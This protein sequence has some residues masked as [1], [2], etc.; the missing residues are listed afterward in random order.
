MKLYLTRCVSSCATLFLV[1]DSSGIRC[2]SVRP[3]SGLFSDGFQITGVLNGQQTD[4]YV[5]Q[6]IFPNGRRFRIQEGGV[7]RA[8]VLLSLNGAAASIRLDRRPCGLLGS[9]LLGEYTLT[10]AAGEPIFSQTLHKRQGTA[11]SYLLNIPD[12]A[13]APVCLGIALCL[14][15]SLTV[16]RGIFIPVSTD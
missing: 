10:D 11:T 15:R 8:Q 7:R 14:S 1:H 4:I 12:D 16:R 6:T 13:L 3:L 5:S 2:C 9:P